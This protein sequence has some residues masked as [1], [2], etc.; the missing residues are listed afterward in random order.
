M[1]HEKI[2]ISEEVE[3]VVYQK[4]LELPLESKLVVYVK[5]VHGSSFKVQSNDLF[6]LNRKQISKIYSTFIASLRDELNV[7]KKSKN[8]TNQ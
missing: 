5:L 3:E 6:N 8:A 2:N 1:T 7:T 4:F